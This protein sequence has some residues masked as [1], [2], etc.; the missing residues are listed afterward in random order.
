MR[1]IPHIAAAAA[2]IACSAAVGAKPLATEQFKAKT[3]VQID[4][5]KAY[6]LVRSPG[7]DLK[8][9]RVPT[10]A[11]RAAYKAERD[12]ALAKAKAKFAREWRRYES[13][14]EAYRRSVEKDRPI[15]RP[16][17]P[18]EP[19]DETFAFRSIDSDN[20]VTIWGG[21]VFDKGGPRTA[22]LIA[23]PAGTYRLYG[24][25]LGVPNGAS[26]GTCL[27]MGSV[28]FDAAAGAITDM[29]TIHYPKAEALK[30]KVE[31]SWNGLSPG[32][33]GL[34]FMRVE[35]AGTAD[36]VPPAIASLPRVAA[37]YRASGKMNN[38]F[39]VMVDRLTPL[40]GVL[41]YR[42]DEVIDERSGQPVGSN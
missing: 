3:V 10:E 29:G 32:R 19:T 13:D 40:P 1:F 38:Y 6:L 33:G 27:C 20:F 16:I 11:D 21:R 14:M 26:F 9:L 18:E 37:S 2:A 22:H 28:Q 25:I 42:R 4:P 41:S 17:K 34:T 7:V 39:G 12:E 8:L 24:Q 36:Y 31:P 35:P 15:P 23:V 30:E 5:A